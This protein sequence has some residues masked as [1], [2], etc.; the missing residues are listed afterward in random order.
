[1][2]L[3]GCVLIPES[4]QTINASIDGGVPLVVGG[5]IVAAIGASGGSSAQDGQFVG[6]GAEALLK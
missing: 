6:A 3:Y 2:Q 5:K 4:F 1:M